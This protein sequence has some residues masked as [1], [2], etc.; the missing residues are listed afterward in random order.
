[1]VFATSTGAREAGFR[2]SGNRDWNGGVGVTERCQRVGHAK[3]IN[4]DVTVKAKPTPTAKTHETSAGTASTMGLGATGPNPNAGHAS[5]AGG[6]AKTKARLTCMVLVK[7]QQRS[8]VASPQPQNP[9]DKCGPCLAQG[10]LCDRS[11]PTCE[12][13][14][15]RGKTCTKRGKTC[16]C[17]G[18]TKPHTRGQDPADKCRSCLKRML[19]C[20][21]AQPTY[22]RGM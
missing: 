7:T 18:E 15:K 4:L 12:T 9:D 13:C 22:M 1:M 17:Q 10:R 14:T 3:K 2:A 20:D 21:K 6:Y 16:Y 8:A 19:R 5:R 11:E